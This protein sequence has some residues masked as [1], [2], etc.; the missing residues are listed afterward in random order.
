[1]KAIITSLL[2]VW[3]TRAIFLCVMVSIVAMSLVRSTLLPE[4]DIFWGARNGS[5]ILRDGIHIF[6]PDTWNLLVIGEEWSPNSWLWNV[7]LGIAFSSLGEYGFLLLTLIANMAAYG[8][9]WAYLQRLRMPPLPAYYIVFGCFLV[10]GIFMNGRSNTADFLMVTTFLYLSH[11]LRQRLVPLIGMTFFLT[12]LWMNLH[13]TGIVAVILFPAIIF[14]LYDKGP[15]YKY[16]ILGAGVSLIALL[17]TPFGFAGLLKVSLVENESK[18]VMLEWSNV[19]QFPEANQGIILL[20]AISLIA[21]FF[22]LKNKH[23]LYA[24]GAAALIYATYDTIRM[25]PYLLAVILGALIY[26]EGKQWVVPQRVA[27]L[28]V[29]MIWL[30]VAMTVTLSGLASYSAQKVIVDEQ[31][32]FT[33]TKQELALIPE[34]ARVAVSQDAGSMAI[35]YR[36]DVLVTLDGRNDL[37]GMERFIEASNILYSE[38]IETLEDWL[39]NHE[40]DAVFV[41]DGETPGADI[42]RKNMEKLHWESDTN[43][44]DAI[45][46]TAP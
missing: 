1:M 4:G 32:M 15:K 30:M 3:K 19:F 9:L 27:A 33:V 46:Y 8:F 28:R 45:V 24:L 34:N 12:V 43:D 5:D 40:I 6:Q 26:T 41:E 16:A 11:K 38:E 7:L 18:G 35:L 13:L 21:V 42:I 14:A 22:L 39:S 23:Y 10:M 20:L 36:P 29:P 37:I 44:T 25:A 31:N 17:C 2:E